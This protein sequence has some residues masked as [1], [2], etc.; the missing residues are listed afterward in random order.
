MVA[1]F[2]AAMSSLD[3]VINSLSATTMEDFVRR[4]H[5]SGWSER[6]ELLYSR[7]I[8][9]AWGVVT[10]IMAF[11]V[12]D[13]ADTVLE[14]INQ[15][16]SLANG[17][18]LAVFAL[19]LLTT[20][21][22]GSGAITGLLAGIVVNA[23]FWLYVPSVSWLWWNVIGFFVTFVMGWCISVITASGR[24]AG[25]IQS[26]TQESSVQEYLATEATVDWKNRS[27]VLFVW[28]IGLLALLWVLG[29]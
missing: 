18:I 5:G 21:T 15:I 19:G 7:S 28:F 26:S 2:A 22:S 20:R 13:I 10:L 6:Q 27:V 4:Y 17:S 29:S 1:L 9:A 14:A 3:S 8:T 16:G 11:Y 23:S 25:A 12:G 24:S